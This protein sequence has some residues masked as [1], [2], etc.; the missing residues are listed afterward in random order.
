MHWIWLAA[1]VLLCGAALLT[2][3][4]VAVGPRTLDRLVS[5]DAL[6]A[7]LMCGLNA[8][9]AYSLDSTVVYGT[10][11]LSLLGFIGSLSVVRF[12]VKDKRRRPN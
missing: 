11:A 6:V 10:T 2:A 1:S 4:K 3:W 9:A 8:W 7:V 12:R 5:V